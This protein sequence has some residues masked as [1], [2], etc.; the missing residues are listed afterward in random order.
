MK[1]A[2]WRGPNGRG[3][4]G[5]WILVPL[6]EGFPTISARPDF[7]GMGGACRPKSHR[8]EGPAAPMLGDYAPRSWE[9]ATRP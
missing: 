5:V 9:A 8:Q 2:G 1:P 4:E 6:A 7:W 3:R